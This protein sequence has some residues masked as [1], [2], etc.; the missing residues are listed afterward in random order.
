MISEENFI[1]PFYELLHPGATAVD[2]AGCFGARL[3]SGETVPSWLTP[4]PYEPPPDLRMLDT[5]V[6]LFKV[7]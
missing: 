4:I 3:M 2:I 1:G 7:R 5:R 6:L